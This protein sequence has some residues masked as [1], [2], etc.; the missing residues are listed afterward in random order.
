M[1]G[2]VARREQ[3]AIECRTARNR[4]RRFIL[5]LGVL[6]FNTAHEYPRMP[7]YGAK[8]CQNKT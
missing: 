4:A 7:T 6:R 2:H 5:A 8:Q 3:V 1:A